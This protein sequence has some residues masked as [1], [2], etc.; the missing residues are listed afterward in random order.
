MG[1]EGGAYCYKDPRTGIMVTSLGRKIT[2]EEGRRAMDSEDDRH[3]EIF[4][5]KD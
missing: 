3:L 1:E 5:G 4:F 2:E